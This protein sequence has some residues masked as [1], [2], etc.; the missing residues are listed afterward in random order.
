M[1]RKLELEEKQKEVESSFTFKPA[2]NPVPIYD[3]EPPL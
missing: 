3:Q 2:I 1:Y